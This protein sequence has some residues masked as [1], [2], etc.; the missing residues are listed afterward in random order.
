M[1]VLL[2]SVRGGFTYGLKLG[3]FAASILGF[4]IASSAIRGKTSAIEWVNNYPQW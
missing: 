3:F 2:A 1:Q 4:T